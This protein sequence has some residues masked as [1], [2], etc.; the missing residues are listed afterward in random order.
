M[1]ATL[2]SEAAGRNV[3][4]VTI[5][6]STGSIGINTLEVLARYPDRFRVHALTAHSRVDLLLDQCRRFAPRR[7]VMVDPEAAAR[8]SRELRQTGLTVEVLSGLEGLKACAAAPEAPIVVA[9]IVGAAGLLPTLSAVRA[10]KRVLFAN[11]EPLVMCGHLFIEEA[12]RAG[13]LLL[14]VD[15]EHNAIFQCLPDGFRAG[16]RLPAV[17]R[18]FLTCSGGPFREARPEV[19]AQATP[20]QA[21]THPN[22][23]MGRKISVDSATLMNKGL[24]LIEA[25]WL[26][27]VTP[28]QVEVVIHPQ[29]I[30]HS[31][32]EYAD[33]SV[34]AQMSHPDMRIPI[35]HALAWPERIE[36]GARRLNPIELA[37]L[38]F[39][40]PD[41]RR[42]PC[43]DLAYGAARAGGTAP[44]ILNAANE[45]AVQ[46]FLDRRLGFTDI[47]GVIEHTRARVP[48]K[49]DVRLEAI[50]EA[51]A[52]AREIADRHIA[53]A[54]PR[55]R[56]GGQ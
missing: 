9:A 36:S 45:I 10:A 40:A 43:L 5:L 32:I 35:A 31:M 56:Q 21:C 13:A 48:S 4:G 52:Q 49:R 55:R 39:S 17:R 19:L 26:F 1:S 24:E 53:G 20:E 51:D 27:G 33:G 28:D 42:F 46:A 11:K 8:L 47:A 29:S 2:P 30:I 41:R 14:P 54:G 50:L 7:A 3:P 18:I 6:G 44:A 38:D 15:S 23:V 22:W 25:C 12:Q 16:S 34:L 37:R